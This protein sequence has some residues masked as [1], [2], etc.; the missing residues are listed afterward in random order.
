[1]TKIVTYIILTLFAALFFSVGCASLSSPQGGPRDTL[2]P[3]V[4]KSTPLPYSLNFKDKKVVFEFNEFVKLKDQQKLFF[5]SPEATKKPILTLK[6]KSVVVTLQDS[7][8][9][10]TT[11]RLDF[12]NSITDNN[13]GNV[14]QNFS[15]VFSTGDYIDSL[16]MVGQTLDAQTCDTVI[17]S[18]V[19]FYGLENDSTFMEKGLDSTLFKSRANAVFRTDSSG[20]FVADI[21]KDKQYRIYAIEDKNGNQRYEPGTDKVGFLDSTYNPTLMPQFSFT[22]DSVKRKTYIDSLQ[23]H[24]QLFAE[25]VKKRQSLS[26]HIRKGRNKLEL[27]FNAE[28]ASYDSLVLDSIPSNWIISERSQFGDSI[29]LW[30]AP[31]T[32]EQYKALKDTI[33]G[34]FVYQRQDSVLNYYGYRTDLK[35]IN[36][37]PKV[38][39]DKKKKDKDAD[40]TV[41][42]KPKNPFGFKVVASTELNPEN[43]I[44]FI[45]N[46]PLRKLDSTR[47]VIEHVMEADQDPGAR[48][49]SAPKPKSSKINRREKTKFT[50]EHR[51]LNQ[52]VINADWKTGEKYNLL[53]PSGVFE[54]I[55]F[56]SNDTLQSSFNILSPDKFGTIT[57]DLIADSTL[58]GS[59]IVE[60]LTGQGKDKAM[61]KRK[62]FLK[63]GDKTVF[64][65]LTPDKYNIRVVEDADSNGEWTTGNL[66]KRKQPERVAIYHGS[67]G[68]KDIIAKENWEIVE[69]VDLKKLFERKL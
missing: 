20:Y 16:M 21:L 50:I 49:S 26:E 24:F 44:G 68:S 66:L 30:I 48:R 56:E 28:N 46:Y 6:G 41:V 63:A 10:Q 58:K 8:E 25:K 13:E 62:A 54:D 38:K 40:T 42:E 32:V 7:L 55:T 43:G 64:R 18:I 36:I 67:G 23:F 4:L 17:G 9:P 27:N 45:F 52:I 29:A 59:Y 69:H 3:R 39:E 19:D 12:G 37:P 35:F 1:M 60:I 34:S 15:F 2:P 53:I 14:L 22:Y 57:V 47:I 33:K 51:G 31:P 61:V 5:M 11:Y 65:Y